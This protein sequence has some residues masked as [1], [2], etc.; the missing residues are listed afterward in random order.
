MPKETNARLIAYNILLKLDEQRSNSSVLL[1]DTLARVPDP[2]DR[3]LVTELVFGVLRRRS[4][5]LFHIAR[6]S[7]RPLQQIDRSVQVILQLGVYQLLYTKIPQHAAIYETVN[8]CR[9]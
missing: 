5:L 1:Q 9:K 8:L 6:F 7:R 2:A 4:T 3:H